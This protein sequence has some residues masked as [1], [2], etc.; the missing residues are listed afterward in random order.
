MNIA[1]FLYEEVGVARN[2]MF[3][4]QTVRNTEMSLFTDHSCEKVWH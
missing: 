1:L 3:R 4:S 2:E